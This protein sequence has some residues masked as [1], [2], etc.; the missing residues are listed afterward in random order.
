VALVVTAF[1][2]D[3]GL[4]AVLSLTAPPTVVP[5]IVKLPLSRRFPMLG[6]KLVLFFSA[7]PATT[8][9][10]ALCVVRAML[11]L[12]PD[13]VFRAVKPSVTTPE[14]SATSTRLFAK[15]ERFTVIAVEA[16]ALCAAHFSTRAPEPLLTAAINV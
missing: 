3:N 13:P 5:E 9:L 6:E 11:R 16:A 14:Y 1:V 4:A 8:Q 2:T 10:L 15:A 12:A 7:N